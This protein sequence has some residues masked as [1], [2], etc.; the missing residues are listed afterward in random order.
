[1]STHQGPAP[2]ASAARL[3]CLVAVLLLTGAGAAPARA[4]TAELRL[5]HGRPAAGPLDLR[6]DGT[7]LVRRVAEA[8]A[9]EYLR[10]P[11]GRHT[12][13]V[14]RSVGGRAGLTRLRVVLRA[15]RAH[16]LALTGARGRPSLRLLTDD[17]RTL[18]RAARLRL[19]NLLP[20]GPSLRLVLPADDSTAVERVGFGTGA[21]YRRLAPTSFRG[22]VVPIELLDARAGEPLVR[23]TLGVRTGRGYSLFVI[24]GSP[25]RTRLVLAQDS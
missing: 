12:V 15:G 24:P 13:V 23:A 6:V 16:T 10:V 11:A 18:R 8:T 3:L 20:R 21:P 9:T 2:P 25:L 7:L 5:F 17:R 22:G 1:M 19:V 4:A 14:R